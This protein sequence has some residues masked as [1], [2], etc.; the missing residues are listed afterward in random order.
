[1]PR[2]PLDCGEFSILEILLCHLLGGLDL[3]KGVTLK[4]LTAVST[5][6]QEVSPPF[7]LGTMHSLTESLSLSGVQPTCRT[8]S[9]RRSRKRLL[10]KYPTGHDIQLG[11]E[12]LP[13]ASEVVNPEH[14]FFQLLRRFLPIGEVGGF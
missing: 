6:D 12:P 11:M 13:M 4:P 7:V 3:V 10:D 5:V 14:V 1:M 8:S 9:A 2:Y